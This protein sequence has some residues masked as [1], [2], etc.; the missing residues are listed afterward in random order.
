VKPAQLMLHELR[1]GAYKPAELVEAQAEQARI[2]VAFAAIKPGSRRRRGYPVRPGALER[3]GA[4]RLEG[5][6]SAQ[7]DVRARA[8]S[9][10][11]TTIV[12]F[13]YRSEGGELLCFDTAPMTCAS[14]EKLAAL[15]KPRPD[16][17]SYE[18]GLGYTRDACPTDALG[19]EI[20]PAEQAGPDAI[21]QGRARAPRAGARLVRLPSQAW[22]PCERLP[23]ELEVHEPAWLLNYG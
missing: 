4:A 20:F 16:P 3:D 13:Y 2:A 22:E 19:V 18:R 9:R 23:D 7:E 5:L 14:A 8:T 17:A 10:A 11:Y 15:H 6:T 12:R 21:A 1:S